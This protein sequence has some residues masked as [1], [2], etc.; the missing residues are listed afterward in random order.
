M[1]RKHNAKHPERS[2]SRYPQRLEKRGLSKAPAMPTLEALRARQ[3]RR[4]EET[5]VPWARGSE[6]EEVAA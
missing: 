3:A 5:G 1:T 4:K 2:R 6:R